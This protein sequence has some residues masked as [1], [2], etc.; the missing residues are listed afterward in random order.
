MTPQTAEDFIQEAIY[1]LDEGDHLQAVAEA[2]VAL[3]KIFVQVDVE[4]DAV[5]AGP[6]DYER[7]N[8][9]DRC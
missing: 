3:A 9:V 8:R 4:F 6:I 2:L 7:H 5:P 1:S